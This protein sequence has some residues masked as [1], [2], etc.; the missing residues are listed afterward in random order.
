MD[1]G[2]DVNGTKHLD[3]SIGYTR[4][5]S[6]HGHIYSPRLYLAINGERITELSGSI[7]N[8]QKNNVSQSDIDLTFQT[9]K[10][11]SRLLGYVMK[12][13]TSLAANFKLDYEVQTM[14]KKGTLQMEIM[15]SNQSTKTLTHKAATLKLHS[16]AYPQLNVVIESWYQQAYG[17]LELHTEINTSPH[18]K[19]DRHKLTAQLVV[20]YSKAYFQTQEAKVSAVV[21]ITKPIQNLDIKLG[22]YHLS[23]DSKYKTTFLIRYAPGKKYKP[24]SFFLLIII[25][26]F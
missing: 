3:A 15:L 2:L 24:S 21:S 18:L 10:V 23:F 7:R 9:K 22:V 6:N 19:D 8:A 13:S 20:T 4:K 16:T 5:K 25:Q 14:P 12:R 1:V 17:H 11:W 26:Y